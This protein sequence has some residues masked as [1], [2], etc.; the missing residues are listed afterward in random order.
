MV[1]SFMFSILD[2]QVEV[3]YM[4]MYKNIKLFQFQICL[5]KKTAN[6]SGPCDPTVCNKIVSSLTFYSHLRQGE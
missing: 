1:N 6:F 5:V 2:R 4:Y 3:K